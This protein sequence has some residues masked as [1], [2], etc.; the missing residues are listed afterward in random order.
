MV[1]QITVKVCNESNYLVVDSRLIAKSMGI[2][3]NTFLKTI[4][5]YRSQVEQT[6]ERLRFEVADVQMPKGAVRQDVVCYLLTENQATF[7]MTLS[8]NTPKVV[9]CKLNLVK[10]FSDAKE[11]LKSTQ[12]QKAP[13]KI[14]HCNYLPARKECCDQLKRHGAIGKTYG[15][16]EKYNNDLVGIEPG[17]R[18]EVTN[19]Q[20]HHLVQNYLFGTI[21]LLKRDLG[22]NDGN[23]HHLA[24][25]AKMAMRHGTYQFAGADSVPEKLKPKKERKQLKAS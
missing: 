13:A 3:H 19:E 20:A 9:Q 16:V 17:N 4:R 24:A 11:L 10:A 12:P 14:L 5:K 2:Q 6:F 1:S 21:E 23:Q 25:T 15:A 8:R 22:F 7:L 18:H